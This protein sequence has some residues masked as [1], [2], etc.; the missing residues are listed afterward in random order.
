MFCLLHVLIEI[1]C[2]SHNFAFKYGDND[3]VEIGNGNK[4]PISHVGQTILST[5]TVN[6]KLNNVLFTPRIN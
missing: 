3:A 6:F 4:L 2:L 5:P 1:Y